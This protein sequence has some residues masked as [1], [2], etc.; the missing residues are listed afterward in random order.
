MSLF[1]IRTGFVARNVM[2]SGIQFVAPE[3]FGSFRKDVRYYFCGD[4]SDGNVLVVWFEIVKS[5]WRV[6]IMT[7]SRVQFEEALVGNN[8]KLCV[9]KK[10]YT[11]PPWL[12]EVDD[13][14]F[15]E[16]EAGRY[17]SRTKT[18]RQ[19]VEDTLLKIGPALD[20]A[21]EIFA[22]QDPLRQ[23]SS[24]ALKTGGKEHPYRWQVWFFAFMLHAKN[25]WALKNATHKIGYWNRRGET[26]CETK[27]GRK[28]LSGS[29]FGWSS[30]PMRNDIHK[31]YL[32][33]C[34]R[35]VSMRRIHRDALLERFGCVVVAD[36]KGNPT[37]SQP[38]NKPFPSY[39]QFRSVVV[40]ILGLESVQKTVYGAARMRSKAKSNL[41]NYTSQYANI[42]E[43]VEVDAYYTIERPRSLYSEEATE[44][45]AV[46]QAV[47]C[48][49][50]SV[51]GIGFSLGAET[52]EAY[53]SMLFCMAVPKEYVAKIYG[54][55]P[56]DLNW[57]MRGLPPN[58]ISDRGPAGH[59]NLVQRLEQEF[60]MKSIVPSYSGQSKACVE[61]THPRE[62][63]LEGA[64][65]YVL[66]N[67]NVIQMMK[68]EI[69]RAAAKNHSKSISERLSDQAIRDFRNEG[70]VAT[71]HH[72]WEYLDKRLRTSARQITLEEAVRAFWTPDELPV[73]KNGVK[74]RHRH[75]TSNE[76][77]A[78]NFM[79]RLGATKDLKIKCY[80][81]SLVVR[82]IWVEVDGRLIELD[83]T[84]RSRV[85]NDDRL[86]TLS[87][88]EDT[89]RELAVLNSQTRQSAE[90]AVAA[91]EIKFKE[92]SGISWDKGERKQGSPKKPTGAARNEAQ[93]A[94]GNRGRRSAA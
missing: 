77:R 11:L 54:I 36:S 75:Y 68:R 81:F 84:I 38:Q 58:F 76:L 83:A 18:Y 28:S 4:R 19:Q 48:T 74:F 21:S 71:P 93:I 91:V 62:I 24:I 13:F 33:R 56:R 53:R 59:R 8:P 23:I 47:C 89:Q 34:G 44:P 69:Y 63:V 30:A 3:G 22:S 90:A 82:N 12:E 92:N 26:H 79:K 57:V 5:N 39:G 78:S 70:R 25:Q 15:D 60:P 41:G 45:L 80:T 35:G 49:T 87:E 72:L 88:F 64:P 55:P 65:S 2:Y 31:E 16:A 32:D 1:G 66:S 17:R 42:L 27:F 9:L 29:C 14:N 85:A 20:R 43:A 37:Y 73:D 10:Q 86:I 52:G 61:S 7:P 46:A 51:V 40:D 94:K 67:L 50:G 6:R